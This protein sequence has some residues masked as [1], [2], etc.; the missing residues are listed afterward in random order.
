[1]GYEIELWAVSVTESI[2]E[3]EETTYNSLQLPIP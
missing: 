2:D 1:M 3:L